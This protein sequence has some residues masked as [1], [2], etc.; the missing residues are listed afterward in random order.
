MYNYAQPLRKK[1]GLA[2]I[3]RLLGNC[4]IIIIIIVVVVVVVLVV[5]IFILI[6]RNK[7]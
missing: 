7:K 3:P 2:I 1:L 6:Y 5:R 4:I